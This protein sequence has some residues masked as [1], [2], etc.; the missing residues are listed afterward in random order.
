MLQLT[1]CIMLTQEWWKEL[2]VVD[3]R[4]NVTVES[5]PGIPHFACIF[6]NGIYAKLRLANGVTLRWGAAIVTMGGNLLGFGWN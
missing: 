3:V 1:G 4:R 5:A 6:W 2:P